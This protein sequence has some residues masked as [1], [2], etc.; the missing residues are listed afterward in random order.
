MLKLLANKIKVPKRSF[1]QT[2][3]IVSL[4]GPTGAGKT[5]TAAKLAAQFASRHGADSVALV[6]IDSY[7]IAAFEQLATYGKIIGCTVKKAA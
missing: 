5:T 3:G 2:G 6:T 4:I 1:L 7:R